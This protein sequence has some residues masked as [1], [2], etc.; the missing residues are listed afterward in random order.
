MNNK[1][2]F[3]GKIFINIQQFFPGA[4]RFYIAKI[5]RSK[6]KVDEI[7]KAQYQIKAYVKPR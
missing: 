3:N 6:I 2:I 5:L 1:R 7:L 4:I